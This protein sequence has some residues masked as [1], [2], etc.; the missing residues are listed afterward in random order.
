[1]AGPNKT[2]AMVPL[3]I[4]GACLFGLG[5][6]QAMKPK[7]VEVNK[8]YEAPANPR[9]MQAPDAPALTKDAA[10]LAA[11]AD[12]TTL[13]RTEAQTKDVKIRI[14]D[15]PWL[16]GIISGAFGNF[17]E[18]VL[19]SLKTEQAKGDVNCAPVLTN[20]D[21]AALGALEKVSCT[22]KDGG[23]ITGEFD[24]TGDGELQIEN[25]DGAMVKVSKTDGDFNVETRNS[26]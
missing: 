9:T 11:E 18:G 6:Y 26:K 24:K 13:Q 20:M 2:S 7:Q 21:A 23:Q 15:A 25:T 19:K 17:R 10:Q 5:T 3:M 8:G 14:S 22:A 1:M 4:V 12:E 16:Q